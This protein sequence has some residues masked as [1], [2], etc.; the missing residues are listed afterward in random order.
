VVGAPQTAEIETRPEVCPQKAGK[1]RFLENIQ[2]WKH[3]RR[4]QERACH[5]LNESDAYLGR[6]PSLYSGELGMSPLREHTLE[7]FENGPSGEHAHN[8]VQFSGDTTQQRTFSAL[9]LVSQ[10]ASIIRGIQ[11]RAAETEARARAL[12]ESA[13]ERL[14]QA[15]TRIN[16][17]ETARANAEDTMVRLSARLQEAERELGRTQARIAAAENKLADAEHQVRL[18]EGRAIQAEKAVTQIDDAIRAQLLGLQ[19]NPTNVRAMSTTD[20][21][22]SRGGDVRQA[23]G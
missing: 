21:R 4:W 15:E 10:V 11:E 14:R 19:R 7:Q 3:R 8:V 12:A 1:R 18:A 9:D 23:V 22:S 17:A 2:R 5:G 20:S 13:L 16:E 6:V